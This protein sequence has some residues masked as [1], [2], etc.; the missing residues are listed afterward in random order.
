MAD[1][2]FWEA[3]TLDELD[4]SEWE[5]LCD[6]CGKCCLAKIDDV[7]RGQIVFTRIACRQLDTELCRCKDY[8]N[9]LQKVEGCMALNT[10]NLD[11]L[12]WF[13]TTCAYRLRYEGKPLYDWHPLI[14]GAAQSVHE[15]GM[16]VAG[17]VISEQHVHP[18]S[19]EE[20]IVYWV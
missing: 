20:H 19:Y 9:R 16:S 6:G 18:D 1:K 5:A 2:P 12:S 8:A 14:S 7:D 15:A 10:G 4:A 17:R 3:K 11:K 13:P